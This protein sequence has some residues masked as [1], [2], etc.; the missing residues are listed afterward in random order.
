M[1]QPTAT[2]SKGY[3]LNYEEI[4]ICALLKKNNIVG[5][6]FHPEKSGIDGLRF[7]EDFMF[8]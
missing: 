1:S 8:L 7:L 2:Q 5:C 6:Q 3:Q 4:K